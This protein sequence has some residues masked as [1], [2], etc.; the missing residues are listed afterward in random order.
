MNLKVL[1]F[2]HLSRNVTN[3][4]IS[5]VGLRAIIPVSQP[6]FALILT[7]SI[8]IAFIAGLL[9]WGCLVMWKKRT[10]NRRLLN[11]N[12]ELFTRI[13]EVQRPAPA[14]TASI[15]HYAMDSTFILIK[16]Y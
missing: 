12:I 4:E 5:P 1:L 2:R 16:F 10:R 3:P 15:I 6:F 11:H 7:F 9:S 13:L 14:E 8:L